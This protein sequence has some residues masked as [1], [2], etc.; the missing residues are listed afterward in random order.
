MA[1]IHN[2]YGGAERARLKNRFLTTSAATI[3][4]PAYIAQ[5]IQVVLL[6]HRLRL[7][8]ILSAFLFNSPFLTAR[9]VI[10]RIKISYKSFNYQ[11]DGFQSIP[12]PVQR[13]RI[14]KIIKIRDFAQVYFRCI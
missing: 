12:I 3:F 4:K 14:E 11:K 1:Q 6:R 9:S 5:P 7:T 10:F 8:Q 2:F 13:R